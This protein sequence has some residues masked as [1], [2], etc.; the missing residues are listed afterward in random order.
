ME[1][2][3]S[4]MAHSMHPQLQQQQLRPDASL[5]YPNHSIGAAI[6]LAPG[7]VVGG[8]RGLFSGDA[9]SI[10]SGVVAL[11]SIGAA[12]WWRVREGRTRTVAKLMRFVPYRHGVRMS[13]IMPSAL[14]LGQWG[15]TA[16]RATHGRL[17]GAVRVGKEW[18]SAY[19]IAVSL[20]A[21]AVASI[22]VPSSWCT[23]LWFVLCAIQLLA[24]IVVAV[25]QPAR[26]PLVDVLQS[27]CWTMAALIQLLAGLAMSADL[28]A[29]D[30]ATAMSTLSL[31][32]MCVSVVKSAHSVFVLWWERQQHQQQQDEHVASKNQ[33]ARMLKDLPTTTTAAR[34]NNTRRITSVVHLNVESQIGSPRDTNDDSNEEQVLCAEG[35]AQGDL[36]C[37]GMTNIL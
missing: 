34:T 33:N 28:N 30:L 11:L 37:K 25:H 21:Q 32:K 36:R 8:V 15:P 9:A 16:A 27:C 24:V 6:L 20:T 4:K 3:D 29:A 1:C 5:K 12:V 22:G 26:T 18:L 7:I 17:R 19:S 31:V 14:P 23:G 13:F 2:G 10:T 35:V